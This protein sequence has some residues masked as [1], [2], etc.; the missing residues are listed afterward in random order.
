MK[1]F[2]L[3]AASPVVSVAIYNGTEILEMHCEGSSSEVAL[4]RLLGDLV[5]EAHGESAWDEILVGLGPGSYTSLRSSLAF[6]LGLSGDAPE[7]I[8]GCSSLLPM[9]LNA[10]QKRGIERVTVGVASRKGSYYGS[11]FAVRSSVA[12]PA[13]AQGVETAIIDCVGELREYQPAE[14]AAVPDGAKV[15][16]RSRK[17]KAASDF[18][19]A[20][21]LV[22]IRLQG[23]LRFRYPDLPLS[24]LAPVQYRPYRSEENPS[25]NELS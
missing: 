10:C 13:E 5:A 18:P 17:D 2:A 11:D 1:L 7:Q 22:R 19:H 8:S 16:M 20:G 9:A 24:Y 3:D 23:E 25:R 15:I 14:W 4:P 12:A 21:D 6:A